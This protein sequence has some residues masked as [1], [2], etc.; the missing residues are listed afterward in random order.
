MFKRT[1]KQF[2]WQT[3]NVKLVYS[4]PQIQAYNDYVCLESDE[5]IIY[6]YYDIEI[7]KK[8]QIFDD[9]NDDL[10]D[11]WKL[12]TK[13]STFDFPSIL[14]F[15][16]I[17]N[18]ILHDINP[19]EDGQKDIYRNGKIK[20]SYRMETEGFA[21][22]DFYEITKTTDEDGSHPSYLLYL[23]TTFDIQGDLNSVGIRT[24]YLKEKDI[25]ELLNCVTAFINYSIEKHNSWVKKHNSIQSRNKLIN[26]GKIYEYKIDKNYD[27]INF[28]E[29]ETIYTVGDTVCVVVL[30]DEKTTEKYYNA[31]IK[32][33]TNDRII[34]ENNVEIAPEQIVYMHLEADEKVGYNLEETAEEF[35]HL[36]NEKEMEEFREE[37]I[38]TLITKYGEAIVNRVWLYRN[39]HNLEKIHEEKKKNVNIALKRIIEKIKK[40]CNKRKIIE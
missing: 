39:E 14:Q 15:K 2:I 24:P 13:R 27:S 21:C 11:K 38:D 18:T 35:F 8:I 34:F 16:Y 7:Y 25:K 30:S 3:D 22:D 31:K 12:V 17:L 10:I 36:L 32:E 6:Y 28:H 9:E 1:K 26:S 23:G 19:A 5:G 20:Y 4:R 29:I 37:N 33:I 40:K